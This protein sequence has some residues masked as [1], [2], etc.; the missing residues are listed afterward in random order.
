MGSGGYWTL[1]NRRKEA[2]DGGQLR[3]ISARRFAAIACV[4]TALLAGAVPAFAAPAA[5]AQPGGGTP[6]SEK[7]G[8]PAPYNGGRTDTEA[9]DSADSGATAQTV[10]GSCSYDT[11][12]DWP[13]RS[14][15]DVSAHGW[16]VF[17]SGSCPA[18]ADV[19]VD[20]QQYW[21]DNWGCRWITRARGSKRVYAGGGSA[22]RANAR[23]YCDSSEYTGWRNVVDVDLV[24]VNDPADKAYII[25]NVY[26]R[27][28]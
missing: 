14:G 15:T 4:I 23:K 9:V 10:A 11:R 27:D 17:L 21:C 24:G 20:L 25:Q 26:C 3:G 22:N 12:G 2:G 18:Q 8:S 7:K 1:G 6:S 5:D 16:W 28:Y 19:T 13:H